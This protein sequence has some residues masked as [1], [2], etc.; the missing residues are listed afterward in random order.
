MGQNNR[1]VGAKYESKAAMFLKTKGYR[2]LEQNFRCH[3]G[4]IDLIAMSPDNMLVFVEIK[5]R[6]SE[7]YGDPFEAV[8]I[9]KQRRISKTAL[10]YYTYHGYTENVPC[11]FDVIAFY[12][13][14]SIHHIENAFEYT[15]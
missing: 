2:I 7:A 13:D 3:Y 10:Y 14:E 4:E 6:T 9:K 15:G 5:Y 11:R 1:Q 8:N 12:A